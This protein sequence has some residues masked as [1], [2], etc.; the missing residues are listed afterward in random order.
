LSQH[1]LP[2]WARGLAAALLIVAS[3]WLVETE[4][5]RA[6]VGD[7]I[8]LLS[9]GIVAVSILQG[10]HLPLGL[11][12]EGPWRRRYSKSVVVAVAV[13]FGLCFV[14]FDPASAALHDSIDAGVFILVVLGVVGWGFSW[15]F[16][17]QRSY[18]PWYA[19][20]IAVA[21]LPLIGGLVGLALRTDGPARL[22]VWAVSEGADGRACDAPVWRTFGFMTA[23]CAASSLVTLELTFRRMLIGTPAR[24]GLALVVAAAVPYG[25]WSLLVTPNMPGLDAPVWL[26]IVG[27]VTAGSLYAL[28]GSLLVSALYSGAV[29]A[30]YEALVRAAPEG[31]DGTIVLGWEFA[32]FHTVAAV[33]LLAW[34]QVRRGMLAGL[35]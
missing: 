8:A 34:L 27:A 9:L 18:A 10:M 12:P 14:V 19:I 2:L 11:W 22:C 6:V 20:G 16:V 24:A 26:G 33:A 23:I 1:D 29:F 31:M 30:G 7:S 35:R 13:A 5:L 21:L 17:E 4:T 28:S 25:L 15:A 32:A 3:W